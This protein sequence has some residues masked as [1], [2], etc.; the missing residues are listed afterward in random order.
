M[1]QLTEEDREPLPGSSS[2]PSGAARVTKSARTPAMNKPST[3]AASEQETD[4]ATEVEAQ[5]QTH[6]PTRAKRIKWSN[7]MNEFIIRSYYMCTKS[8][9]DCTMWR[10]KVHELFCK[11]FPNLIVTEQ[12]IADQKRVI[13]KG[14]L[15]PGIIEQIKEEVRSKLDSTDRIGE[16][17][18]DRIRKNLEDGKTQDSKQQGNVEPNSEEVQVE[19]TTHS[20]LELNIMVQYQRAQAEFLNGP[21]YNRP[22]LPKI[23]ETPGTKIIFKKVNECLQNDPDLQGEDEVDI[24][25]KVYCAAN[26]VAGWPLIFSN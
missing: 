17:P 8:E 26:A 6:K 20:E 4:S 11:K 16:D 19:C 15:A 5:P 13:N 1:A 21:I 9:S 18:T 12:R 7:D 22:R 3:S 23:K 25:A 10:Q 24:Y 2:R 14:L